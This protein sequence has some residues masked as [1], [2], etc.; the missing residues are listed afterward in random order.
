M[1][2]LNYLSLP[3]VKNKTIHFVRLSRFDF[4]QWIYEIQSVEIF[5]ES[6]VYLKFQ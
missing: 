3:A 1:S 4:L 6:I 5:Y 2:F